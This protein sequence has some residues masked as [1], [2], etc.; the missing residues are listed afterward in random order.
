MRQIQQES[1]DVVNFLDQEVEYLQERLHNLMEARKEWT[2]IMHETIAHSA[3]FEV[4]CS[5][6]KNS[7]T[8]ESYCGSE[9]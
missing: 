9:F 2:D 5:V 6:D 7:V 4:R 1:I 8:C 3:G